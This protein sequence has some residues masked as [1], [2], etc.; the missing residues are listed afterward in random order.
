LQF[1]VVRAKDQSRPVV[2]KNL[3]HFVLNKTLCLSLLPIG[4]VNKPLV[5]ACRRRYELARL[6]V[7]CWDWRLVLPWWIFCDATLSLLNA[8]ASDRRTF[9][10]SSA[11][12]DF[13]RSKYHSFFSALMSLILSLHLK[14]ILLVPHDSLC[15]VES[16][17]R[18][19]EFQQ[20]FLTGLAGVMKTHRRHY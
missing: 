17:A 12:V 9:K 7:V 10:N 14:C 11:M 8:S 2:P 16:W 20:G 19:K 6:L 18:F 5:A 3:I 4:G 13:W 1:D 15:I